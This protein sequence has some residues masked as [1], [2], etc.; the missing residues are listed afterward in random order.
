VIPEFQQLAVNV[1]HPKENSPGPSRESAGES[2]RPFWDARP[3]GDH[4]IDI[5]KSRLYRHNATQDRFGL[6]DSK[7]FAQAGPP[8]RQR[9]T[10]NSRSIR[11]KHGR[12]VRERFSTPKSN[13]GGV[14]QSASQSLS[15]IRI[16]S[17]HSV[18]LCPTHEDR[19]LPLPN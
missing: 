16:P 19:Q 5:S 17:L 8:P 12:R 4:M 9:N 14:R 13:R 6:N 18:T 11:R 15:G 7:G 2:R 3:A 1:V 10:Q